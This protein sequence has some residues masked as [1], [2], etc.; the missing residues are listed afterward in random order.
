MI[1]VDCRKKKF[2]FHEGFVFLFHL[3]ATMKRRIALAEKISGEEVFSVH[4]FSRGETAVNY[5]YQKNVSGKTREITDVV[6][7]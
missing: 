6:S 7:A 2:P 1:I 5:F 4:T 3:Q